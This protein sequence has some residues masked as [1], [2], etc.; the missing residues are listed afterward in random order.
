MRWDTDKGHGSAAWPTP[1]DIIDVD[2]WDDR[3]SVSS[4]IPMHLQLRD[5][6]LNHLR[7]DGYLPGTRLPTQS[8]LVRR[9]NLGRT[10]ARRALNALITDG[11]A[12]RA[13]GTNT[14]ILQKL[15]SVGTPTAPPVRTGPGG[16]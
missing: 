7:H 14:L 9:F 13:P 3:V 2:Q 1:S 5:I 10:T 16:L 8:S 4:R 6:L 15:P 11:Y 12:T